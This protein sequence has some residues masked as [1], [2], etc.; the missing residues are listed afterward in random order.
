MRKEKWH[1]IIW[2]ILYLMIFI[3]IILS[4]PFVKDWYKWVY[5]NNLEERVEQLEKQ[6]QEQLDNDQVFIDNAKIYMEYME[7]MWKDME[8]IIIWQKSISWQLQD[9]NDELK[10]WK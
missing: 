9:I 7:R 6:I 1:K 3:W 4:I 2:C 10:L 5:I 8:D